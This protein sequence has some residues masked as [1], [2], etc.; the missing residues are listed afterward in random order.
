MSRHRMKYDA[1]DYYDDQDYD[2]LSSSY[3]DYAASPSPS[4]EHYMNKAKNVNAAP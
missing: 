1:D 4:V 2:E 3:S